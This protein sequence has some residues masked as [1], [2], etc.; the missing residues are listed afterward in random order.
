M[1]ITL[2]VNN[3]QQPLNQDF[4]KCLLQGNFDIFNHIL[5]N[6]VELDDLETLVTTEF[7]KGL[8]SDTE[9]NGY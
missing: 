9:F 5:L 4:N 3:E 8:P 7:A 6:D 2:I 1:M